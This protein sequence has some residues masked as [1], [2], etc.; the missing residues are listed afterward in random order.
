MGNKELIAHKVIDADGTVRTQSLK[1]HSENVARMAAKFAEPYGGEKLAEYIG[2][3]HDCGKAADAVQRHIE[4]ENVVCGHANNAVKE[5]LKNNSDGGVLAAYCVGGHHTGLPDTGTRLSVNDGTLHGK[6]N[7]T[8]PDC[9]RYKEVINASLP[10]VRD[11]A[12]QSEFAN[13]VK[14]KMHFSGLVDADYLD[15]ERFMRGYIE[16][17]LEVSMAELLKKLLDY[18]KQWKDPT[19]ELNKK[20][21][22]IQKAVLAKACVEAGLFALSAPTSG[23]KTIASMLFSIA[24]AIE[25]GYCRIFVVV[26]YMS[27]IDQTEKTLVEIFGRENVLSHYTNA[28]FGDEDDA[29]LANIKRLATENW[30]APIVLTTSVQ[31]FESCFAS[32]PGKCRKIHNIGKSVIIFDEAQMIPIDYLRPCVAMISELALH[33]NCSIVLSTATQPSLKP[34]F[35]E[36]APGMPIREL[37]PE[38]L[39]NDPV[40]DRVTFRNAGKMSDDAL[41]RELSE[42]DQVLCIVNTKRKAMELYQKMKGDGVFHLSTRMPAFQRT[43][44]LDEIKMRLKAGLPCKVIS[45]SLI[46]CGVDVDFPRVYRQLAGLDSI[47]QAAGRCNREAKRRKEDSIVT[48]FET[49]DFIPLSIRQ[50][51][52]ATQKTMKKFSDIGSKEAAKYYFDFLYQ[53]LRGNAGLDPHD[54]LK[55]AKAL[56]FRTVSERF[57]IIDDD[58][59]SVFIPFDANRKLLDEIRNNKINMK[60]LRELGKY[61]VNVSKK[62][63]AA[64]AKNGDIEIVSGDVAI[65]KNMKLFDENIGLDV[66]A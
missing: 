24:H 27:I 12:T 44:V 65:L 28:D 21:V 17:G 38:E 1:E 62:E 50:N 41:V 54:I 32:A 7:S 13:Y 40:F 33:Y 63:Y 31:F 35:A 25:K 6:N 3:I 51:Y 37:C 30:D 34:F 55:E 46:E 45:T 53:V 43:A 48:I 23:S 19:T 26:P 16:R 10:K 39:A 8:T 60:L 36:F 57:H 29:D 56:N 15:T 14:T 20:R 4:G 66:T 52:S 22:A 18:M 59:C 42:L 9:S 5:A 49:D 47:L 58:G 11:L 2:L 64:L 61:A